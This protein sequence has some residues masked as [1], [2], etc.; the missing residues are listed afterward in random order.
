MDGVAGKGIALIF[1]RFEFNAPITP[2]FSAH[3]S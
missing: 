3:C 2:I 1:G